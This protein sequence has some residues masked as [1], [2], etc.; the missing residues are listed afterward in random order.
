MDSHCKFSGVS[1][2]LRCALLFACSPHDLSAQLRR[3]LTIAPSM[4]QLAPPAH[5]F[6]SYSRCN[7]ARRHVM[8]PRKPAGVSDELW[9]LELPS[10]LGM[11]HGDVHESP[12]PPPTPSL[13]SALRK[14]LRTLCCHRWPISWPTHHP[15]PLTRL[16]PTLVPLHPRIIQ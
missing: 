3:M 4:C 6:C 7:Q 16:H 2:I 1:N 14:A 15:Q 10:I 8:L 12:E 11:A 9:T 13:H 5:Q